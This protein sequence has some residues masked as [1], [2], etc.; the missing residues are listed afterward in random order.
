MDDQGI[1]FDLL[2]LLDISVS[3]GHRFV[4]VG[5][6]EGRGELYFPEAYLLIPYH[7]QRSYEQH[8]S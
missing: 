3:F 8:Y 2:T 1:V 6:G 7:L 5:G 4:C